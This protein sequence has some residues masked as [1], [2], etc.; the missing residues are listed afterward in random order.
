MPFTDALLPVYWIV[1]IL[2]EDS[3]DSERN[4]C[5]A[6]ANAEAVSILDEDSGDSELRRAQTPTSHSRCFNPR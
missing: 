6:A 4:V 3:G 1:S 5:S 2:D